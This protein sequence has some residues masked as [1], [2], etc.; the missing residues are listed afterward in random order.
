TERTVE[1]IVG[2]M[3]VLKA[4]GAYLAIALTYPDKRLEFM[5]RDSCMETLLTD[6]TRPLPG[7]LT[8]LGMD[9]TAEENY[10]DDT[11]PPA[12]SNPDSLATVFYTSG[13]TG[14]PKG[15]LVEH[16]GLVNR[17]HWMQS[18]YPIDEKDVILQKTSVVFDVSVWELF[19]WSF[20][21]A[22]VYLVPPG[23]GGH[24]Q[25]AVDAIKNGKV[26]TMHFTPTAMIPFLHH[27]EAEKCVEDVSTLRQVFAS[28]EALPPALVNHFNRL[29]NK[30]N[31]TG[32]Y[33]LYGPTEA[34]VDVTYYDCPTDKELDKVPI[35]KPIDNIRMYI[36]DRK[37]NLPAKGVAGQLCIAGI[38]LARGYMN[39]PNLTR[40]T[41][42]DNPHEPGERFYLTGDLARWMP[43]GNI[44]FLGRIDH[45]VQINGIRIE[46]GE[47][48]SV[49][50]KHPDIKEA[51]VVTRLDEHDEPFLCAYLVAANDLAGS[52]FKE[53]LARDLPHYML[54]ARYIELEKLPT[55]TT[56][57]VN[58]KVLKAIDLQLES[59]VEFVAPATEKESQI[60][61]I[62]KE[63]LNLEQV[64]VNDNFF[65][66]GGNSL[67]IIQVNVRL[68]EVF[69]QEIPAL[70]MFE[71]PTIASMIAYLEKT[72][73]DAAEEP[74]EKDR[75]EV[76]SKG[77]NR[78]QQRKDKIKRRRG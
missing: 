62:W 28:G 8:H 68:K 4:G 44:E 37:L 3:A 9:I 77:R 61:E 54:P 33:N 36:V 19:W 5:C 22:S 53:S 15:V 60:A 24:P 46:L 35:G 34:S 20:Y 47:I 65:D 59:S 52:D 29:L 42:V 2:M 58:R 67:G 11:N 74:E 76:K 16:R 70:I 48:E 73:G 18:R 50:L 45:Q 72:T 64:G 25:D 41:F 31:G 49:L 32:L 1:M 75:T 13:S 30:T 6:N 63:V 51:V 10:L 7:S 27:V 17:I 57:K 69:R 66:I 55:T 39:R 23:K 21:G 26:T 56:G 38:G 43:D 14:N 40:D 71:Y 78:M 12:E